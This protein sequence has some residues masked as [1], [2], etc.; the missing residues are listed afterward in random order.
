MPRVMRIPDTPEAKWLEG[1]NRI[2]FAYLCC[3]AAQCRR[4]QGLSVGQIAVRMGYVSSDGGPTGLGIQRVADLENGIDPSGYPVGWEA[5]V[6][7][8]TIGVLIDT[9]AELVDGIEEYRNA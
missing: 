9:D 5:I 8:S 2:A 6:M 3:K 4:E 7:A 1:L